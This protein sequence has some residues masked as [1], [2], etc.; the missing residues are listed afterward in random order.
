MIRQFEPRYNTP[1]SVFRNS[2]YALTVK[3]LKSKFGTFSFGFFWI[4]LEPLFHLIIIL[5]IFGV[6]F[7]RLDGD[8]FSIRTLLFT[9]LNWFLIRDIITSN[10]NTLY[11]NRNYLGFPTLKPIMFYISGYVSN[12]I[13]SFSIQGTF[14]IL[15]LIFLDNFY[16][17]NTWKLIFI[18]VIASFFGLVI[19]IILASL[20]I[21]KP[22]LKKL[23]ILSLRFLYIGSLVIIPI[24]IIPDPFSIFVLLNP[25]AQLMELIR[26]IIIPSRD[27]GIS[28]SYILTW[29]AFL[30]PISIFIYYFIGRHID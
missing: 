5:T 19:S 3:S 2:V 1:G 28:I 13:T 24:N 18:F 23:L 27:F 26:E 15:A 20:S 4:F 11:S 25:L 22:G 9:I 14:F 7:G 12:I 10:I 16:F 29:L 17:H 8:L 30:S 21:N 6:V